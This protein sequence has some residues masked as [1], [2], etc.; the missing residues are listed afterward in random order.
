MRLPLLSQKHEPSTHETPLEFLHHVRILRGLTLEQLAIILE[1]AREQH[2]RAGKAI[3]TEGE[4]GDTMFVLT[5][6]VV[7]ITIPLTLETSRGE[8]SKRDKTL[9]RLKAEDHP[10]FGEMA[11]F[12]SDVRTATV[13]AV[14][15]CT[16]L[17]LDKQSLLALEQEHLEIAYGIVRGIAEVLCARV[18]QGNHDV[19][20]LTTA[21]SIA[22]SR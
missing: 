16:T 19:L 1:M 3:I 13:T 7:E 18:H 11:L 17:V 22:L 2:F 14:T 8:F 15:D 4:T 12:G 6:G 21:L 9:I 20:K 10:C 5:E